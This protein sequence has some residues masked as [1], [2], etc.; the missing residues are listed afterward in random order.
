VTPLVTKSFGPFV[1]GVAD[2]ANP[3]IP[4]EGVARRL[5]G[6]YL[7][8][9]YRLRVRPGLRIALT[10]Y[11]DQT[12]PAGVTSVCGV[13]AFKDRALAVAHSAVTSKVYLYMLAATMDA[14]Y[15]PGDI[16]TPD[17]SPRP[18]GVLWSAATVAP[19]VTVAEGLGVAYLAH[20]AASDANGLY[21]PTKVFNTATIGTLKGS[22]VISGVGPDDVY[23]LGVIGFKQA[24]WGWGFG[25]GVVV[26][27]AYRPEMLRYSPPG[28]EPLQV[29][30]SLTVGDRVRSERERIV[31]AGLAGEALIVGAPF[32]V[33]RVT[34]FGRTSWY[35]QPVDRSHGFAGPKCAVSDGAYCYYWSR[36]GPMRIGEAGPPDALWDGVVGLVA[37]V[38]NPEKT[39][40]FRDEAR[41][42]IGF[43]V[44]TGAGVRTVCTYDVR[45][46]VWL[47][48]DD[49]FGLTIAGAG[50]VDQVPGSTATGVLPPAG[51]PTAPVTSAVGTTTAQASWTPGDTTAFTSIEIEP[52]LSALDISPGWTVV[53][54]LP[55]GQAAYVFTSLTPGTA[56][57][58]RVK[59]V[60]NQQF[61]N[62][63]GPAAGTQFSTGG[64]LQPPTSLALAAGRTVALVPLH[65]VSAFWVN[66]GESDVETEI[67]RAGPSLTAPADGDYHVVLIVPSNASS[68]FYVVTVAGTY[69]VKVRHTN[70]TGAVSSFTPAASVAVSF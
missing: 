9:A 68:G 11:D 69:W 20:A 67:W 27:T 59:H 26:G 45:R 66:S 65:T 24:L 70:N 17:V 7:S 28:F 46:D 2:S 8:G 33:S 22:G 40:A 41:D 60:K 32:M 53:T 54:L 58:W 12:I 6:F 55:P 3:A 13:W 56:Y 57:Q 37:S 30:D 1:K 61:S 50:E 19:N 4:L 35:R 38:T 25:A 16:L 64:T 36:R 5:R 10:L 44:D 52:V 23:F 62:Y 14:W 43:I 39:V 15:A 63:L 34:G 49:D 18:W 48:P 31:G 29:A 42:V 21:F 47:G 51:P